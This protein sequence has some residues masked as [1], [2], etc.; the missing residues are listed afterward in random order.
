MLLRNKIFASLILRI[1][2]FFALLRLKLSS[3][4]AKDEI[5][6]V[7]FYEHLRQRQ[8]YFLRVRDFRLRKLFS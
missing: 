7:P 6:A 1:W 5:K 8:K 4:K 3:P 2:Q